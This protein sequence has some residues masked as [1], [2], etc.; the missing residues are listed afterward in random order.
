MRVIDSRSFEDV[1]LR[2]VIVLAGTRPA[3][4]TV[5]QREGRQFHG[6]LYL[7]SGAAC[8]SWEE[9]CT[10]T[11]RSGQLMYIP[12]G[13]CYKMQY[14]EN[15]T[16]FVL[17]NL[18]L[19]DKDGGDLF[20]SEDLTVLATDLPKGRIDR[21]MTS[22]EACGAAQGISAAL[23]RKELAF[24]LLGA[25]FE[26]EPF[27]L[28]DEKSFSAIRAGA[29]LLEETYLENLPVSKFAAQSNMSL[30]SF[31]SLFHKHYGMSPVQY[32]NRLRLERAKELLQEG[33]CTVSEAA[34]ACGFENLGYF[35]RYYK[36]MT[37]ETP[38]E[39]RSRI[40]ED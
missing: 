13:R 28:S 25:V 11:V 30:S 12:K 38:S 15:G 27:P 18:D 4:R 9:R 16:S 6:L 32:R 23:R 21:I 39:T 22:L 35:C 37:G 19:I 31:R 26:A 7:R 5:E 40:H 14:V 34:Y 33:I 20:L 10:L 8:F 29:R 36:R 17:V 3:G 24:R 2:H 1:C